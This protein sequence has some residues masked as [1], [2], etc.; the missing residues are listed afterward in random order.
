M[1]RSQKEVADRFTPI[2]IQKDQQYR[3]VT[4]S[5]IRKG[6]KGETITTVL[7]GRKETEQTIH[8]DNSH[9]VCGP[10]A[11]EM[12]VVKNESFQDNYDTAS[13][14]EIEW[15]LPLPY[16]NLRKRGFK[17]Y[18][19][20]RRVLAQE[21]DG[22]DMKWFQ[23]GMAEIYYSEEHS[24]TDSTMTTTASFVAPVRYYL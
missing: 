12:Y 3:K 21:V 11:F 2:L 14:M 8:E 20:N 10:S 6:V 15:S 19:S 18:K 23:S 5:Y 7:W 4:S 24:N 9:V 22:E 17:E 16:Q 13:P 1:V